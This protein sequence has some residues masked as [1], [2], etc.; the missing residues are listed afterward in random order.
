M[1]SILTSL[2]Q[3][4]G[5]YPGHWSSS[6]YHSRYRRKTPLIC[7][8]AD[9]TVS[10]R[11][12]TLS[13]VFY[14]GP[15]ITTGKWYYELTI[16]DYLGKM[17]KTE[18]AEIAVGWAGNRF[19]YDLD[20]DDQY[21]VVS[22]NP[23]GEEKSF[24][25]TTSDVIGCSF[26]IPQKTLSISVNGVTVS[27]TVTS[28]EGNDWYIPYIQASRYVV[29]VQMTKPR[30]QPEGFSLIASAANSLHEAATNLVTNKLDNSNSLSVDQVY[31]SQITCQ[32]AH[33]KYF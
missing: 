23:F 11:S 13:W 9:G 10:I 18:N 5:W 21:F 6:L 28:F 22:V 1:L 4:M 15:R 2:L 12:R 17:D 14:G 8:S 24:Q 31:R 16:G 19:Y 32:V 3:S 30:Y 27:T 26:D 29:D 25:T 20:Q 33:P 7:D